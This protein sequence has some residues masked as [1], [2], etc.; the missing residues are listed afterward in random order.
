VNGQSTEKKKGREKGRREPTKGKK[1]RSDLEGKKSSNKPGPNGVGGREPIG[2]EG[3][4][5]KRRG[6]TYG[7]TRKKA[8]GGIESAREAKS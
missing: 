2:E 6:Y 3:G 4:E 5:C 1:E 7:T 8:K